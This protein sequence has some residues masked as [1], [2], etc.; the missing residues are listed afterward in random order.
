MNYDAPHPD[1]PTS[2][3]HHARGCDRDSFTATSCDCGFV[4]R[5]DRGEVEWLNLGGKGGRGVY[6]ADTMAQ[7]G[8]RPPLLAV[9]VPAFL[10][11]LRERCA[12]VDARALS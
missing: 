6:V 1:R 7:P 4:A 9:D 3:D 5:F 2:S 10:A 12:T 11:G 8:E